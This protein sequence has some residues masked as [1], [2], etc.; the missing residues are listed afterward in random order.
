MEI[1]PAEF[2]QGDTR[3]YF[4]LEALGIKH[5]HVFRHVRCRHCSFVF[6]NPR[7]PDGAYSTVYGEAKRDKDSG[8]EWTL[9]EDGPGALYN[10]YHK[11]YAAQ[12]LLRALS[13]LRGRFPRPKS[14]DGQRL[15]LLDYGSGNGHLLALCKVFGIDAVG[16]EIDPRR[17]SVCRSQGLRVELPDE[18][19][20]EP[21]FD[22]VVSTSVIEHVDDVR[23]YFRY[24]AERLRAGGIFSLNGLTPEIIRRERRSGDYRY[25]MPLEHLNFF[26]RKSFGSLA[27]QMGFEFLRWPTVV[28]IEAGWRGAT[29]GIV[30]SLLFRG[31]YPSGDFEADLVRVPT[32]EPCR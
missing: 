7:L 9:R 28:H 23:G 17:L 25:V 24:A 1:T 20:P 30:K 4:D 6:V 13:H 16:V 5:D 27:R 31:F 3:A 12:R 2:L 22:A 11:W 15:R 29:K 21:L 32:D 8:E 10:T 19:P 26:T 18:V 14:Q